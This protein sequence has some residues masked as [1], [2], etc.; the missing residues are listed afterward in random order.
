[1][2]DMV[3]AACPETS[4][5]NPVKAILL[6]CLDCRGGLTSEVDKCQIV[7]CPLFPFRKGSNP[8]RSKREMSEEQ[9][10][11]AIERLNNIRKKNG[12]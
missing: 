5:K 8:F 9:R 11:Q 7:T 2:S 12:G 3:Q 6:K 4:R 1:M 10:T